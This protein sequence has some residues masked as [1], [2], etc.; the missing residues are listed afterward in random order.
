MPRRKSI[1]FVKPQVIQV[2]GGAGFMSPMNSAQPVVLDTLST[3]LNIFNANPYLIGI[4]YLFLN[5]GGRF[6]SLELTKRQEW[7]LSQAY[8]RP[9]ILFAVMFISTRNIAVA[10][11]TTVGILSV[12]WVFANENSDFCL[13]PG[14]KQNPIP[15]INNYDDVMNRIKNLMKSDDIHDDGHHEPPSV[16][17]PM[18]QQEQKQV[19]P[20]VPQEETKLELPPNDSHEI[21]NNDKHEDHHDKHEAQRNEPTEDIT[22]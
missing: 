2:I 7:F 13:V 21:R 14:W 17:P 10:F 11:W 8:V 19:V 4:F 3:T 20:L 16:T 18:Q 9:F 1:S 5:L 6:L 22:R 15:P 12:L